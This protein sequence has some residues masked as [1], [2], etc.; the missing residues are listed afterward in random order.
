MVKDNNGNSIQRL[1]PKLKSEG[2]KGSFSYNFGHSPFP[3]HTDTAFWPL[4]TR[5]VLMTSENESICH[6]Y[7]FDM[8]QIF[9]NL[10]NQDL[11]ILKKSVFILNIN[12]IQK[13]SNLIIQENG[14]TGIRFDP[15]IMFPFNSYAKKSV[16]II[17]RSLKNYKSIE[18]KWNGK[19]ILILDN[20]RL[21]HS[22]GNSSKDRE[23]ILKRIY[24]NI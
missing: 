4:P 7:L 15:N 21:L 20:W 19:N 22:R 16:E 14:F 24:I 13:F 11:L 8:N 17:E 2:I 5:Y 6:T 12:S 3:Y 23:R 9:N 18:I 1:L 10:S